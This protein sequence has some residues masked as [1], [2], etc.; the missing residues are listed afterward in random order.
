VYNYWGS[1]IISRISGVSLVLLFSQFF[2]I[3]ISITSIISIISITISITIITISISITIISLLYH[4]YITK[5]NKSTQA[6]A[7]MSRF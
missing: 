1:I 5:R 6:M 3:T 4:Y 2:S 7:H